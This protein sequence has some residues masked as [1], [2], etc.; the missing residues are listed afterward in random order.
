MLALQSIAPYCV[1]IIE[2]GKARAFVV[3]G[4][5]I[6]EVTGRI[7]SKEL[8]P[9]GDDPRVGWS[10]HVI[11]EKT[12]HE[13]GYFKNLSHELLQLVSEQQAIGLVLGCHQDLWGEVEPHFVHLEKLLIGFHLAHFDT[14]PSKVLRMAMPVFAEG[15]R[16]RVST[17]L[18]EIDEA[19]ARRAIGVKDVL[20]ALLAGRVERLVLGR[21]PGQTIF[22]CKA[23]GRMTA[24]AGHNCVACGNAE[25]SYMAAEEGLIRR[26]LLTDAEILFFEVDSVPGFN[27]AAALLHY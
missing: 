20:E 17:V 21:L 16:T 15:Q 1:G 26:G 2:S 10:K 22:G 5:E 23:C 14:Q 19:P 13:R 4:T 8:S 7:K 27:G 9:Q 18:R 25:G 11:K 6:Q 12:E 3:R 24:A